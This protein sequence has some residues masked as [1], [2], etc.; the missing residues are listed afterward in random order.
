MEPVSVLIGPW[1]TFGSGSRGV[2][3]G[4]HAELKLEA[5]IPQ[6][7]RHQII[8]RWT[9]DAAALMRELVLSKIGRS[10]TLNVQQGSS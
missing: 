9:P 4:M 6:P 7:L 10:K 3:A 1:K 2:A 5:A 8:N